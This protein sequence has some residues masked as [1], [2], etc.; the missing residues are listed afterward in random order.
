MLS[1]IGL[2]WLVGL[3][4]DAAP[5]LTVRV[6]RWLEVQQMSGTVTYSGSG[7][8]RTAQRGDRLQSVGDRILTAADSSVVL[9]V[10]TR[11]GTIEVAEDTSVSLK[12]LETVPSGGY[13]T[14]LQVNQGR[15]QLRV[16]P[17]INPDSRLEIQT[18]VGVSGVRGTEF[19]VNVAANGRTGLATLRGA[20]V[21]DAQ[22]KAVKVPAGFQ[23]VTLPGEPPSQPVP[24]TNQPRL[25]YRLTRITRYD[26]QQILLEGQVEPA[27]ALLIDDQ[28]QALDR[29]GRFKLLLPASSRLRLTATVV[30]PLGQ[31]QSYDL[32]L[33]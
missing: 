21:S 5:D 15:V 32:E 24:F 33:F 31:E 30:T 26:R 19:G 18:P 6:N 25:D 17:F 3:P 22:G 11:I 1:S 16:R 4:S 20:V 14:R 2:A 27:S 29:E 9:A 10:D 7:F 23:N 28:P 8:S 13:I 12:A